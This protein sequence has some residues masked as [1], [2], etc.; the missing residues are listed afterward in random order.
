MMQPDR[1]RVFVSY[2]WTS[3]EYQER[4]VQLASDLRR[5]GIDIVLDVWDLEEG[6]DAY[7]F[8]ERSVTDPSVARVLILCDPTYATKADGRSGGVGTETLIISPQVYGEAQ[9]TKFLPVVMERG[10]GGEVP[11][12]A[13]LAGRLYIDLSDAS[14]EAERYQQLLRRRLGKPERVKPPLGAPPSYLDDREPTL[15]TGRALAQ[16]EEAVHRDRPQRF[17]ML[18]EYLDRLLAAIA[19]ERILMSEVADPPA[20]LERVQSSITAFIPYRDE[21]AACMRFMATYVTDLAAYDRVHRFFEG[22][23]AI[24]YGT[25]A[26]RF[27]SEAEFE[28][29]NF[30]ARELVL[31]AIASLVR[32]EQFAGLGRAIA[33][34]YVPDPNDNRGKLRSIAA[35]DP[36]FVQLDTPHAMSGKVALLIRERATLPAVSYIS[37]VEAEFVAAVRAR[38]DAPAPA[39]DWGGN[40][41]TELWWPR[42][43][44]WGFEPSQTSLV[45]RLKDPLFRERFAP[46]LGLPSADALTTRVGALSDAGL[47]GN[48]TLTW[49]RRENLRTLL[50]LPTTAA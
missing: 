29:L 48:R 9:Q 21:F 5:D 34:L 38:L 47:G 18:S 16:Y 1:P 26:Q 15:L 44:G 45:T 50:G 30:L 36:G 11:L 41:L 12:P 42:D 24:L 33:P 46:A 8:M 13:Y 20:L 49:L 35:M 37:V 40:I 10:P 43:V 25:P 6:Q 39:N 19:A 32:G 27:R 31:Y 2:S 4:V 28:N 3:S 17:G 7:A 14:R 23:A 22:V